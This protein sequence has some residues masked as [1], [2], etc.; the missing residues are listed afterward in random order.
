MFNLLQ[1]KPHLQEKKSAD[2]RRLSEIVETGRNVVLKLRYAAAVPE[3][4]TLAHDEQDYNFLFAAGLG[5]CNP[6]YRIQSGR[7]MLVS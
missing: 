5:S 6:P 2:E 3:H 1:T 7:P 4:G